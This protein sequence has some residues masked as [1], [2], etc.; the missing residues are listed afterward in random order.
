MSNILYLVHRLPFPPNK[1]DKVR[2]YHLLKHLLAQHRVF[3]GT[4][5]DTLEDEALA[6]TVRDLCPDHYIER[7]YPW[8]QKIACLKGF[9]TQEPLTL[10]YYRT[11][12][13]KA[14]VEKTLA[15]QAIDAI[16]IFSSAM[17]QYVPA[18]SG[19]KM[20]AMLVDFVDVDSEKWLQYS[21]ASHWPLSWVYRR[22][23]HVLRVFE[24]QTALRSKK[25][26]FVTENE[27]NLFKKVAPS[28]AGKLLPLGNGVDTQFFSP[29][30]ARLSPFTSAASNTNAMVILFTGAMDYWPNI[31]AVVWFSHA[32][33]PRLSHLWPQ[34]I[35][36][37][38]GRQPSPSVLALAAERVVVTGTVTDVRPYLQYATVV[39]APLRVARGVQ[40]KILEAMAM[41]RPVVAALSC[42]KV[43]NASP[44]ELV[45]T[46]GVDGFLQEISALLSAPVAAD[47]R[48]QLARQRVMESYGWSAHLSGIDHFLMPASVD[49]EGV[50]L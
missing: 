25:S 23:G 31:D 28:C 14:W 47:L 46:T 35:F 22:E 11:A 2:S 40:N 5:M 4:F 33:W 45:G 32:V 42:A 8:V 17:A 38:V 1:G 49:G 24:S 48:G 21:A 12:G 29:D 30:P 20:P 36:Y 27:T 15:V 41:S 6:A 50:V 43:I 39:V 7:L 3:L 26:F 44:D 18:K 37:I 16:V 13:F 34:L 9:L 19:A 10:L